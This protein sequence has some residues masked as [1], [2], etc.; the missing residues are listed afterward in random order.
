MLDRRGT[1]PDA[2]PSPNPL[3]GQARPAPASRERSIEERLTKLEEANQDLLE[4][5]RR[6]TEQLR[7]IIP[8]AKPPTSASSAAGSE[9]GPNAGAAGE[10]G[11]LSSR[12]AGAIDDLSPGPGANTVESTPSTGAAGEGGNLISFAPDD[13]A[14]ATGVKMLGR[15]G[16]RF[17]NNGLWFDSPDKAF[18]FH[19]GGRT[20]MDASF[21][22]AGDTVQFGPGGSANSATASTPPHARPDGRALCENMR[23]A[24]EFDFVNSAIPQGRGGAGPET[25]VSNTPAAGTPVPTDLWVAFRKIP[26]IG[27]I[28]IGNQKEPIGFEHLTSSRFLN[29]M[30]RSFNQDAFYGP[31]DN[32]FVP[33]IS[34][35]NTY[36]DRRGTYA[37][38][39]FQNVTNPYAF[40]VGGG[41]YRVTGR[42][43]GLLLDEDE[44]RRLMHLGISGRQSGYDNGQQR[45]R[46]RGP[47]RAGL[48]TVWPLY[49]N[50][51]IFH[52]SGSQQ[53]LNLESVNVFGP[54]TIDAEYNFHWSHDTSLSGRRDAGTLFYSGGYVEVLY[55]LT[56][57]HRA[58]VRESGPSTAS[59]RGRTPTGSKA[60]RA[61]PT[62][63]ASGRGGRPA[64]TTWTST[65]RGS[66]A[67]S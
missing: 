60:R 12:P 3:P 39:L 49:A 62:S 6:L 34:T 50:T 65:T 8:A 22:S 31:F 46:V 17:T 41:N 64:T 52:G 26:H 13:P 10:G 45:F 20:Q 32:G 44:G 29:F 61:S 21:F 11:D 5:N 42:L 54:W 38:G 30:E 48:S 28:R 1:G 25:S 33:G 19:V 9:S 35:F 57:E 24:M 36:A 53:D 7:A 40:D 66:T 67:A 14:D 2:T 51:P 37:L 55:F 18:Q 56:G 16:R 47:E 43:T 27:N 59:S 15:F 63:A 4:Q 23:F 58:Y